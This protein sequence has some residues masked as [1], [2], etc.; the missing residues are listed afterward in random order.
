[1][2]DQDQR[3]VLLL[4]GLAQKVDDLLLVA[5]VDVGRRL[6]GKDQ[7]RPVGQR[8]RHRHPLLLAHREHG[9]LVGQTVLQADALQQGLRPLAFRADPAERHS[10]ENILHRREAGQQIEGLVNVADPLRAELIDLRLGHQG[11][12]PAVDLHPAGRRTADPRDDVQERRLAAAAAPDEHDLAARV[13][14]E[15]R[16]IQDRQ[17]A[18]I[19]L[20]ERLLDVA[21]LQQHALGIRV[22]VLKQG[23][24]SGPYP[25]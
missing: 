17:L 12:V 3:D 4:A 18:A 5:D 8:P 25:G 9:R 11:D 2:G 7:L 10:Q 13:D 1:V 6:V 14:A 24:S 20:E 22:V 16:N 23:A 19:R 21:K 15:F